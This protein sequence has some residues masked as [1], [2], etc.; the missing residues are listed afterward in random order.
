MRL[1]CPDARRI[2]EFAICPEQN[3]SGDTPHTQSGLVLLTRDAR[4]NAV[5]KINEDAA[6]RF[7]TS[8]FL[9][10]KVTRQPCGL[11]QY[12]FWGEASAKHEN[13]QSDFMLQLED[14]LYSGNPNEIPMGDTDNTSNI[15]SYLDIL[16]L[17]GR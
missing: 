11:D 5:P 16:R 14:V 10:S 3:A 12:Q 8:R 2:Y 17:Q 13:R 6:L 7:I 1:A 15:D 9:D 4:G